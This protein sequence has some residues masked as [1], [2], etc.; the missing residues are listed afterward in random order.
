M[1]VELDNT[2]SLVQLPTVEFDDSRT[3]NHVL[4]CQAK[5]ESRTHKQGRVQGSRERF[6]TG[7]HQQLVKA[8]GIA[9]RPLPSNP[10]ALTSPASLESF[11][12]QAASCV[13]PI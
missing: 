12:S 7:L 9:H 3:K 13:V 6:V 10:G 2:G 8:D 5:N 4:M 11:N 1:V